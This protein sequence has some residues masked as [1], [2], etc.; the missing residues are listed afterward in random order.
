[1]RLCLCLRVCLLHAGNAVRAP[2]LPFHPTLSRQ[3][4]SESIAMPSG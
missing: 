2:I 3:P 4:N 1:M